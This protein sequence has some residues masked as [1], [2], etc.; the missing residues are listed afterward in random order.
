MRRVLL[1]SAAAGVLFVGSIFMG[2]AAATTGSPVLYDARSPQPQPT[3]AA[4][5]DVE[6]GEAPQGEPGA[7]ADDVDEADASDGAPIPSSPPVST[8]HP[9]PMTPPSSAAPGTEAPDEVMPTPEEQQTWLAFQQVVR[10]CMA[11]AG[12][13][14]RYWE[15]WNT[16][17]RDP[18]AIEP[19]MPRGLTPAASA[20][21][22]LALHGTAGSGDDAGPDDAGCWGAALQSSVERRAATPDAATPPPTP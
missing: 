5:F 10:E 22:K 20:A 16:A 15:W 12:H 14:Y 13:E 9:S 8:A 1:L 2:I 4:G 18:R 21:W 7:P 19:A 3:A 11:D 17:A 6:A